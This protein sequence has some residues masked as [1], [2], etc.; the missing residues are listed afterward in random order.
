MEQVVLK[1]EP[2][3]LA[4]W[5]ALRATRKV[6]AF[7]KEKEQ[8]ALADFLQGNFPQGSVEEMGLWTVV[9]QAR[10]QAFSHMLTLSSFLPPDRCSSG[11][12]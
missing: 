2:E 6:L 7:F 11:E 4:R 12:E 1:M 10:C 3:E 9:L 5:L 8:E